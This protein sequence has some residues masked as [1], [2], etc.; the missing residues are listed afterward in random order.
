MAKPNNNR[1]PKCRSKMH[2]EWLCIKCHRCGYEIR[3]KTDRLT[4]KFIYGG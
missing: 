2:K 1:C 3:Q 4:E